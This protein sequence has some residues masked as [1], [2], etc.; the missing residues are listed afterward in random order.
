[1]KRDATLLAY[2]TA[3]TLARIPLR[4]ASAQAVHDLTGRAM[5]RADGSPAALRLARGLGR[6]VMPERPT[7][8]GGVT[9]PHPVILA[10]GLVKGDG[11]SSEADAMAAVDGGRD[12][13]PGWR[14]MPALVGPVEFGSFTRHPR[15]G[16][17]GTVIWRDEAA[18]STC[19]RVGLRNPGARAA[20]AFLGR[21]ATHLPPTWGISLAV[22][23]GLEDDVAAAAELA[24]AVASFEAA[25][26]GSGHGP[27][28]YTLNL[29][30]PNTEDDPRASQTGERSRTLAGAL[31]ASLGGAAP[32]W[33]K[34]GPAL[35]ARQYEVLA[36][37]LADAGVRAIVATN[38]L[39]QP[40]PPGSGATAGLAGSGLRP[41]ALAAVRHL[42]RAM[43]RLGREVDIVAGGGIMTRAHVDM[44][45]EA[46][47]RAVMVYSAL[48]FRGPLAAALVQA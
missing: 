8:V 42:A 37:V 9:L 17:P 39:A 48:V 15:V 14:I 30:C 7:R 2:R 10:A 5:R 11:F 27:A 6:A 12:I 16:N 4:P 33:V 22:S 45:R 41:H 18:R 3:W 13:I 28:W 44:A 26:R 40:W 19:N 20:A 46:G 38:T 47:A 25:L 35:S 29:S 36:E 1:M 21:R 43:E 31:V 24:E 23:P 32:L 34:V